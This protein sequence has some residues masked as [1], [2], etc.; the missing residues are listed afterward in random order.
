MPTS[1]IHRRYDG[2]PINAAGGGGAIFVSGVQFR[3]LRMWTLLRSLAFG[4][5]GRTDARSSVGW[6]FTLC[7]R[8]PL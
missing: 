1:H 2:V 7:V 3:V 4:L 8:G 5:N 6:W